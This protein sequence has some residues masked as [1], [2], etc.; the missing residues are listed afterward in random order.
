MQKTPSASDTSWFQISFIFISLCILLLGFIIHRCC[1]HGTFLGHCTEFFR[2]YLH[3]RNNERKEAQRLESLHYLCCDIFL[4]LAIHWLNRACLLYIFSTV[5]SMKSLIYNIYNISVQYIMSVLYTFAL[6][7][8]RVDTTNT[9][10]CA[11]WVLGC[12]SN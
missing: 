8:H 3:L 10:H 12:T 9:A 11:N 2:L 4:T 5:Y 6:I 7:L 1:W